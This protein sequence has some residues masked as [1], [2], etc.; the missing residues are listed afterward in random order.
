MP[1]PIQDGAQTKLTTRLGLL[2]AAIALTSCTFNR[3]DYP[4][5]TA[6]DA[7]CVRGDFPDI[8][9]FYLGGRAHVR[10]GHIDD[11]LAGGRGPFCF[12]AGVRKI[13]VWMSELATHG[14]KTIQIEFFPYQHIQLVGVLRSLHFNLDVLD[15]TRSPA[16]VLRSV[17][18]SVDGAPTRR[19]W[20][21]GS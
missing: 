19:N 15:E 1:V 5:S 17:E 10:I 16:T 18:V 8:F 20:Q 3:F 21:V 6:P 9:R 4:N 12:P 2:V 11:T 7:A 13:E 14:R